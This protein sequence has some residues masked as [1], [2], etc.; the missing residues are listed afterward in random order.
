MEAGGCVEGLPPSP[1]FIDFGSSSGECF[2]LLTF[3]RT[4]TVELE[5]LLVGL[6]LI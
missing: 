6:V 4:G 5:S 3:P 2:D 1:L